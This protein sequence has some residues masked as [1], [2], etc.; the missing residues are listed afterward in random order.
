MIEGNVEDRIARVHVEHDFKSFVLGK[1]RSVETVYLR[2]FGSVIIVRSPHLNRKLVARKGCHSEP[3]LDPCLESN[4][5]FY[6]LSWADFI[7]MNK[8]A[9]TASIKRSRPNLKICLSRILNLRSV[10]DEHTYSF[11]TH[12]DAFLLIQQHRHNCKTAEVHIR[13]HQVDHLSQSVILPF[14]LQTLSNIQLHNSSEFS[15]KVERT[16]SEALHSQK[17]VSVFV[18]ILGFNPA[19]SC[20][21]CIGIIAILLVS[22]C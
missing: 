14:Q 8:C 11:F 20:K 1:K 18:Q 6:H 19:D 15:L 10:I 7:F 2:L 17:E 9:L 13:N 16:G 12:L 22:L 5:S 4:F 21:L 3:Y